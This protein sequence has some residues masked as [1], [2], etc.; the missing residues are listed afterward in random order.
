MI[1]YASGKHKLSVSGLVLI[2]FTRKNPQIW[3]RGDI[4]K[5]FNFRLLVIILIITI[6]PGL[7]AGCSS[8]KEAEKKPSSS[9][10]KTD[11]PSGLKSIRSELEKLIPQLEQTAQILPGSSIQAEQQSGG[12]GGEQQ[13]EQNTEKEQQP[14]PSETQDTWS[15]ISDSIKKI[16]QSWNET[17]AEVIKEGLSTDVRDKFERALEELTIKTD[18]KNIEGSMFAALEVY[19][20]YPDM[21]DLFNSKIPAEFFRLKYEVMLIRAE[22]GRERWEEARAELPRLK[23]QW[24]ILKKNEA[25][26]DEDISKK[27]ENS[28]ND[29]EDAV[30]KQEVCL[31][32]IKSDIVFKNMDALEKKLNSSM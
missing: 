18:E 27:T 30:E 10:D 14:P 9:S 15:K 13:S 16:H 21:V 32:E 1:S 8:S 7:I 26:K 19:Q 11:L 31:V 28:L 5:K 29:L 2:K 6:S 25:L 17:E 4:M 24:D 22:S 23:A 3:N 12:G 20:Y